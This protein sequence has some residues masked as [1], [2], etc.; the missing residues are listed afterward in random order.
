[1]NAIL[2]GGATARALTRRLGSAA[3]RLDLY[4][5]LSDGGR[6]RDTMLFE[7]LAGPSLILDRAALRIE[8]RGQ[9]VV[10]TRLTA[11][12]APLLRA[13]ELA[14]PQHVESSTPE[15]LHLR[16]ERSADDDAEKRLLAPSPFDVLRALSTGIRSE[17]PEE[18]FTLALLGIV[19]F[20]HVDLFEDLPANE[21]DPLG[22]PDFI[23]WA[24]ESLVVAEIGL[25]PRLVCA[26]FGNDREE[27][28]RAENDAAERLAELAERCGRA[29][30]VPS[31][32]P[33]S[34]GDDHAP[35]DVE[36]DLDDDEFAALVARMKD[37][38]LAGDVYQIVPSRSF[39]TPCS[40]PLAAFAAVRS[41][42][43]SPYMFY[44]AAPDHILFGA[45]PE[46]SVR[47]V[48]EEGGPVIEVKPIAGTRPRG[49]D[50]DEDDRMEADLRLD[51]KEVAEH[52]M[53]VDL[54]RNDVA[55]V[56][57]PGT[58]RVAGLMQVERYAR[59]MHLVSSVKGAL[60]IGYDALHGLAACLN[61][62]TLSGAPKI[63]ATE[64][65]RRAERTRRG[66]YGGA[67]GWHDGQGGMDTAV[68]IR[69]ALVKDGIAHVRAG[70]G[71]V[72]DSDP[73]A[74]A[75]ETRRKAS[76][77]LSAIAQAESAQ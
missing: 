25:A 73:R 77:I 61:V 4:A 65:L 60:A 53:L 26:S 63:K 1:V 49:A 50:S 2:Q 52:M 40:D 29:S 56:S 72:H 41:L 32:R 36:A 8:C 19:A 48:R 35:S 51:L 62:G 28:R 46:T 37:H 42:D 27:A 44:V 15:E 24:A 74:E 30:D 14:L 20:D 11:G 58:R 13:V 45:S 39:R 23:F 16:F 71:V 66:P 31:S 70:A 67:I 47:V 12:G 59:V 21:E 10:L 69:S 5:Q 68:V 76:A 43:R 55:R 38:V 18:P 3:D 64:L 17:T 54:A 9:E 6:R 7:T 34:D 33:K 22:F 57:I 75:D